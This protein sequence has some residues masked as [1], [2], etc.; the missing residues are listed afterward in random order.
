VA[1]GVRETQTFDASPEEVWEVL[2]D[3][4]RLEEWVSAHRK[5]DDVPDVPLEQGDTF[6]QR[7]GVGPVGFWV[8]WEIVEANAPSLA[9]WHGKGPGGSFADVTYKLGEADG[10]KTRFDY[11]NDFTPPGGLLGSTAKK[12]VNSAVGQREAR[13]SLDSLAKVFE[14]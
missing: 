11:T 6:R 5:L 7:L 8:E 12:A 14:S 4:H 3:P 2:M 9:R 1:D 13:K 10:G